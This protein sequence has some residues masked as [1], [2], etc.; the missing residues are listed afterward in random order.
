M[1]NSKL[2]YFKL[3]FFNALFYGASM[4]YANKNLILHFMCTF[5]YKFCI[6]CVHFNTN[7]G[8]MVNYAIFFFKILCFFAFVLIN[9][10]FCIKI[11]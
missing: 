2:K 10:K 6:L 4:I 1:A 5:Q 7:F 3:Y 9:G 8:I 11:F